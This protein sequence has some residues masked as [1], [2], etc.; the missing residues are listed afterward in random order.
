[1]FPFDDVIMIEHD[2][3][4]SIAMTETKHE[5]EF[6]LTKI[7]HNMPFWISYGVSILMIWEKINHVMMALHFF[8]EMYFSLG[9]NALK[10]A[11]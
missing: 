11:T 5:S 1:M 4:Y 2:F 9:M 8:D 3:A 10:C 7:S 6:V